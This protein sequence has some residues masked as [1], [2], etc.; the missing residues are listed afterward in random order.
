[1][2]GEAVLDRHIEITSG[3]TGQKPRIGGHRITAWGHSAQSWSEHRDL[4]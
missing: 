1:M 2:T 4:A 3:V